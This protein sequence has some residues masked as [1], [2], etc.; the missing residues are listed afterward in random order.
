MENLSNTQD[1]WDKQWGKLTN[2]LFGEICSL[3]RKLFISKFVATILEK[4]FPKE[5]IFVEAGCG[6]CESSA[7]IK[8]YNR[9]L[10]P[11][12]I[13]KYILTLK[14][15][16]NFSKP[17]IGDIRDMKFPDNSI[18]G[19]WNLGVMEHFTKEDFIQILNEFHRVLKN[20]AYVILFIPPIF[21]STEIVLRSIESFINLFRKKKFRFMT[22]EI[23]PVRSKKHISSIIKKSKLKLYRTHFSIRDL[24]TYYVVVCKKI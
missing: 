13:S 23:T 8:K 12:D 24:Y 14:L 5:G 22:E 9:K 15:P 2:S 1:D 18:D 7:R 10:I 17:V 6:T 3:H 19:I 20:G 16:N 4:Y 21:G 11:F